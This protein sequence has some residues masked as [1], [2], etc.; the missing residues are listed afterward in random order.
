MDT[1]VCRKWPAPFHPHKLRGSCRRVG[2]RVCLRSNFGDL[3]PMLGNLFR[4]PR[5]HPPD[6]NRTM[7]PNRLPR[8][9]R[10][11]RSLDA[12]LSGSNCF[13]AHP[14]AFFVS[15]CLSLSLFL[16]DEVGSLRFPYEFGSFPLSSFNGRA[17]CNMPHGVECNSHG[18]LKSGGPRGWFG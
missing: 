4:V 10:A 2:L 18:P 6:V 8:V 1:A 14:F 7:H 17:E 11:S 12:L 5:P 13:L 3:P 16:F 15:F 9:Q